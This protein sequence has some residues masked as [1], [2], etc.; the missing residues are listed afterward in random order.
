MC[1]CCPVKLHASASAQHQW[2]SNPVKKTADKR[3]TTNGRINA[4]HKSQYLMRTA[5]SIIS[6]INWRASNWTAIF[7]AT[8]CTDRAAQSWR[9][10]K[11]LRRN[12]AGFASVWNVAHLDW[13]SDSIRSWLSSQ[14][15]LFGV[16]W[17]GAPLI[18]RRLSMRWLAG[19]YG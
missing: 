13:I 10:T 9:L 2:N 6:E 15:P 11:T 1:Q 5:E 3:V 7:S 16:L 4:F 12:V 14:P 17:F 18:P 8:P 19:W